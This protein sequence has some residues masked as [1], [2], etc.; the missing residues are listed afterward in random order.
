MSDR[1]NKCRTTYQTAAAAPPRS[2]RKV[3]IGLGTVPPR[4]GGG[5]DHSAS[6]ILNVPPAPTE[7]GTYG[8]VAVF[9]STVVLLSGQIT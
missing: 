5:G 4:G 7:I 8:A 6:V 3:F 9:V 1:H 2:A